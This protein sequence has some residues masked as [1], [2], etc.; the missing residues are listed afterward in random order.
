MKEVLDYLTWVRVK[1]VV[2]E[3]TLKAHTKLD[4]THEAERRRVGGWVVRVEQL[5]NDVSYYYRPDDEDKE[6]LPF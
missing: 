1:L 5:I 3:E 2:R 4:G 6:A